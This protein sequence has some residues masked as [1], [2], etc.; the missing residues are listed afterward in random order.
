[1]AGKESCGR[2][3]QPGHHWKRIL[4]I[5]YST[6]QGVKRTRAEVGIG[7]RG[8][9]HSCAGLLKDI[10]KIKRVAIRQDNRVDEFKPGRGGI[11]VCSL[12]ILV[13]VRT[14]GKNPVSL[15]SQKVRRIWGKLDEWG[16]CVEGGS[17][18]HKTLVGRKIQH[19][20]GAVRQV[21]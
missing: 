6:H 16:G 7:K 1:M 8:N 4:W 14:K 11:L 12:P 18:R 17:L 3:E 2:D 15:R 10:N 9:S 19:T 5:A 20:Q 21:R 13:G